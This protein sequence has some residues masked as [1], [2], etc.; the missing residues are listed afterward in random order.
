MA[1]NWFPGH[2]HKAR[3][4]IK[5]LMP[6]IDVVIEVLDARLPYSSSNPLVPLLRGEKP[7]LKILNKSDLADP[8]VTK[9]WVETLQ[10]EPGVKAIAL[11]QK[12]KGEVKRILELCQ[13]MMP[14]GRNYIIKPLNALILG[15]PNV[16]KS[17]L[18]NTLAD[19]AIAQTGNTPAV[20]KIQQ[21]IK[22]PSN[23]VLYDTPGFLWPRLEP[24]ACGYRLALSAAIKDS[25]F[26]YEDAALFMAEY[27]LDR[28][29]AITQKHFRLTELPVDNIEMLEMIAVVR[30]HMRKGGIPDIHKV[31]TAMINDYRSGVLGKVTL[32]TPEMVEAELAAVEQAQKEKAKKEGKGRRS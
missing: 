18:I 1:I 30:G 5:Q 14:E 21:R 16:G 20:T 29:P 9:R 24:E 28:Y 3:K 10:Q 2:M 13:K 32:E 12:Q 31:A 8:A 27:L 7:F 4:E 22:L 11:H 26:E 25:I 17:T 15:I 23:I 6:K 19:R